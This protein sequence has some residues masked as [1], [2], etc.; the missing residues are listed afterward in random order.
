MC[1]DSDGH[2]RAGHRASHHHGQR[3]W[4]CGAPCTLPS[5]CLP[6]L[7][8]VQSN[9]FVGTPLSMSVAGVCYLCSFIAINSVTSDYDVFCIKRYTSHWIYSA[10][11]WTNVSTHAHLMLI[12]CT[13]YDTLSTLT[14][15]IDIVTC[16]TCGSCV[17]SNIILSLLFIM[18]DVPYW[19]LLKMY[20]NFLKCCYNGI[21]LTLQSAN[22]VS[23]AKDD[24]CNIWPV[25]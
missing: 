17:A 3:E 5:H 24:F 2:A 10:W 11:I 18:E 19:I 13:Y 23:S 12:A 1:N 6:Q 25:E 14:V 21:I 9:V 22:Y 4:L 20:T 8:P 15:F 16:L 7:T